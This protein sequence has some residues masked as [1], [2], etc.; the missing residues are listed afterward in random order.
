MNPMGGCVVSPHDFGCFNPLPFTGIDVVH[1]KPESMGKI[2]MGIAYCIP[3]G[4]K[5]F[6]TTKAKKCFVFDFGMSNETKSKRFLSM[7]PN[8]FVT[9]NGV[10]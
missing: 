4:L 2:D 1:L 8:L 3:S 7:L 9:L 5:A 10:K 6:F